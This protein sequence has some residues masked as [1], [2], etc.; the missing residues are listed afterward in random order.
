MLEDVDR[1]TVLR[2]QCKK[3]GVFGFDHYGVYAGNNKVIHF[4][5]GKVKRGTIKAFVKGSVIETPNS[6]IAQ[7]L[8]A[9]I[10][11]PLFSPPKEENYYQIDVIG[12]SPEFLK[13]YS[14]EDSYNRAVQLL[15][16]SEYDLLENNCEH[17]SAWCRTGHAIS[18]QAFGGESNKLS[19]LGAATILNLPRL[20]G[21]FNNELGMEV[22]RK[23]KLPVSNF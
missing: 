6:T 18:S 16:F 20:I 23:F 13:N 11:L 7:P 19:G 10:F 17:F 2:V 1:G 22:T 9:G 3:A 14:K 5:K 21:S 8:I 4:T 12:F 15:N